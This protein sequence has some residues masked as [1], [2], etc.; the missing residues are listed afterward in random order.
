MI[1]M[2]GWLINFASYFSSAECDDYGN[3]SMFE[4]W[5]LEIATVLFFWI[6]PY[7]KKNVSNS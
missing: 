2:R 1:V 7:V 6:A 5:W 4:H 3:E